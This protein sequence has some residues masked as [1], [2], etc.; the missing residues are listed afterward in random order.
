MHKLNIVQNSDHTVEK[1]NKT[2]SLK[3]KV[4]NCDRFYFMDSLD[5]K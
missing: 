5:A 3:F 1:I 4:T 2:K